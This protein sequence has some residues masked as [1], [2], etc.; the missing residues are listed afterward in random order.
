[1]GHVQ[2]VAP[3]GVTRP[4]RRRHP[5]YACSLPVEIRLPGVA[6]PSQ[7]QTTDV[8]LCGCYISSRFNISI[9]TTIELKLWVGDVGVK[10]KAIVRTSDP[11]V[12]NGIEFIGIDAAGEQA[13]SEYF[14]KLDTNPQPVAEKTLRDLLI[15]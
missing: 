6:F 15:I 12:G 8:S 14:S 2:E 4:E 13:L 5:R 10:T 1:M 7:G 11:G 9:G 3:G